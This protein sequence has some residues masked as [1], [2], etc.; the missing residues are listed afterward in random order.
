MKMNLE[1]FEKYKNNNVTI[2]IV[3]RFLWSLIKINVHKM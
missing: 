2:K 3:L 1:L